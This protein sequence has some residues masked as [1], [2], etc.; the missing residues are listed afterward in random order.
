IPVCPFGLQI[1]P[2]FNPETS[3]HT[4]VAALRLPYRYIH[5]YGT[6]SRLVKRRIDVHCPEDV[7]GIQFPLTFGEIPLAKQI[8][9]LERQLS[10]NDSITDRLISCDVDLADIS[11]RSWIND[12]CDID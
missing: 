10:K 12:E 11:T 1:H 7:Q 2:G 3:L 5:G 4:H 8:T 9:H 6:I